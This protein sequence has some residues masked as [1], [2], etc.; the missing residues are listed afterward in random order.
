MQ[1]SKFVLIENQSV[2]TYSLPTEEVKVEYK[3]YDDA[4]EVYPVV[5]VERHA[6]EIAK[7]VKLPNLWEAHVP[8]GE[9]LVLRQILYVVDLQTGTRQYVK[10]VRSKTRNPLRLPSFLANNLYFLTGTLEPASPNQI[11]ITQLDSTEITTLDEIGVITGYKITNKG[12]YLV[13]NVRPYMLKPDDVQGTRE[14]S[15]SQD[16]EVHLWHLKKKKLIRVFRGHK[17]FSTN[18]QAADKQIFLSFPDLKMHEYVTCPSE[19][20]H[21]Y[22]WHWRY[23]CLLYKLCG[24]TELVT[25]VR[26]HPT[27]PLIA[28][29]SDDH[30]VRI[31]CSKSFKKSPQKFTPF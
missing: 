27:L 15:V 5:P 23:K 18:D 24:H 14:P 8:Q 7:R 2:N 6:S 30:S 1:Q 29:A 11:G 31:W 28:S 4:E 25:S 12:E 13:A 21:V 17:G 22:V 19:E 26:I 10:R 20:G 9:I 3:S 16:C